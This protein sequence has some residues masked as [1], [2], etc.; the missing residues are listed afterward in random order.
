VEIV[1]VS[2]DSPN[3]NQDWAAE[4]GFQYELWSDDDAHT[5]SEYYDSA[6]GFAAQRKTFILD[7]SGTLVLQYDVSLVGTHPQQV[8]EDCQILFGP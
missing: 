3:R 2:Y 5:L 4:E 1:G 6:G 8:L 7:E